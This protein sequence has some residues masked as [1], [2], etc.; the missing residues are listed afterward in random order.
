VEP[1]TPLGA[2]VAISA[3]AGKAWDIGRYIHNVYQGSKTVDTRI[4]K[5]GSEVHSLAST[6]DLVHAG[7]AHVLTGAASEKN[8]RPYD[9]DGTLEKGIC[10]QVAHREST[11]E[12]LGKIA[13]RLWPRRKKFV[14]RTVRELRLQD[15][16]EQIDDLRARI[17][18]HTD[19]LHTMLLV[20]SIKVAHVS[21]G[22]A[23]SQLP[24]DLGDLRESIRR[25]EAKLE[26]PSVREGN[27]DRDMPALVGYARGTL[28]S[29][30][31][32]FNES[33]A[34]S[35]VGAG[36]VI[37]GEQAAVANKTVAER[38]LSAKWT[39][40][41]PHD[42]APEH[43][44]NVND[45]N[46][47]AQGHADCDSDD[48]QAEFANT[49]FHAGVRA[50]DKRDWLSAGE[51]FVVSK[52]T[53]MKLPL[54]RV[55][56]DTLF[57][58]Q[59]RIASCLFCLG[60]TDDSEHNLQEILQVEPVSDKQ[61]IWQCAAHH[62]LALIYVRQNKLD[63]AKHVCKRTS[64]ARARVL[65]KQHEQRLYSIA[66][67][68]RICK[69]LGDEVESKVYLSMIPEE[70][71]VRLTTAMS[72]VQPSN[73]VKAA[74]SSPVKA[75]VPSSAEK[76]NEPTAHV[77][78]CGQSLQSTAPEKP[79]VRSRNTGSCV[80]QP[81]NGTGSR[82]ESA[83][84]VPTTSL[85]PRG[86]DLEGVGAAQQAPSQKGSMLDTTVRDRQNPV[87][88]LTTSKHLGEAEV[89][90]V[91]P[92]IA[93]ATPSRREKATP[94]PL[95][96]KEASEGATVFPT[97]LGEAEQRTVRRNVTSATPY[98]KR[99]RRATPLPAKEASDVAPFRP[100]SAR[101]CFPNLPDSQ[102][103]ME[104]MIRAISFDN[105]DAVNAFLGFQESGHMRFL[106]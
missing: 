86:H 16:R 29:G 50:Y 75:S 105:A 104:S 64:N 49:A 15:A 67:L 69:L 55:D 63:A 42:V 92:R 19:A 94:G 79:T 23:L 38:V 57:W 61:R 7:L 18:S 9:H 37:G 20:L 28:R 32:L 95:P 85:S 106:M 43:F 53:L 103:E 82:T 93:S 81:S 51:Y 90:T 88:S 47:R 76:R 8:G 3:L 46:A 89:T 96:A 56:L 14:D 91:G 59:H 44:A 25:I 48:E 52:R 31:T 2:A 74:S 70:Q 71:R 102:G 10:G 84:K 68:S 77:T 80:R 83:H 36:S 4:K 39:G 22:Q 6:C 58:L 5:L 27:V 65:G 35:V 45:V 1:V 66:L 87:S 101:T 12:E 26:R 72:G 97:S 98:R 78:E 41:E 54:N 73:V 99:R 21:P 100:M 34:G 33:I 60:F 11:I 17:R 24:D 13:E 40:N 62:L 30:M